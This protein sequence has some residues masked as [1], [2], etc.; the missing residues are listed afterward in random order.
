MEST[1]T[2]SSSGWKGAANIDFM[3]TH[4]AN[5]KRIRVR[6]PGPQLRSAILR[7]PVLTCRS[8]PPLVA[9]PRHRQALE[10]WLPEALNVRAASSCADTA[11]SYERFADEFVPARTRAASGAGGV[12]G[13]ER[14]GGGW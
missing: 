2:K 3:S 5:Q 8:P 11:R 7:P 9:R 6:R 14:M 1:D 4:P 12:F 13:G 10:S